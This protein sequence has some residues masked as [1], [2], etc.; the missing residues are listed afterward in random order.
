[1][2]IRKLFDQIQR[3]DAFKAFW[4]YPETKNLSMISD[5]L[6]Y[7]KSAKELKNA[8]AQVCALVFEKN[9]EGSFLYTEAQNLLKFAENLID[10]ALV[11][12]SVTG[13]YIDHSGTKEEKDS[14]KFVLWENGVI[15]KL[16]QRYHESLIEFTKDLSVTEIQEHVRIVLFGGS[17][18]TQIS[19]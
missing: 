4:A 8:I 18:T 10:K 2:N 13:T 6:G 17:T 5:R 14:N 19:P 15:D 3:R 12:A 7:I 1:M 9:E 16:C 11:T